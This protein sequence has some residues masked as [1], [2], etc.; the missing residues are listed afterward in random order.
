MQRV[1]RPAVTTGVLTLVLT[2]GCGVSHQ[3]AAAPTRTTGASIASTTGAA[4]SQLSRTAPASVRHAALPAVG[5]TQ[6][7]G[8]GGAMLSVTLRSV[9][10]P[11]RGSGAELEHGTRAV[12]VVFQIR[13][14]GPRVYDSSATADISILVSDGAVTPVL[15]TRGV[16]R[17]PVQD[18]DRYITEGEDRVGCVVFAID[19]AA[20]VDAVR[21][22]PYGRAHRALTWAG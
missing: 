15:A 21:F 10:D 19:Y 18:F 11:L 17:T 2:T 20:A 16:C 3:R 6:H 12:G 8:A 22:A 1:L 4:S 9:I 5:T 7:I 13:S 14:A